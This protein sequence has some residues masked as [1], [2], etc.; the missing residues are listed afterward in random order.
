MDESG[1]YDFFENRDQLEGQ[2]IAW[3]TRHDAPRWPFVVFIKD[4][5]VDE[6][7][8]FGGFF[9]TDSAKPPMSWSVIAAGYMS[10]ALFQWLNCW[11][12][13]ACFSM[14]RTRWRVS[15]GWMTLLRLWMRFLPGF[16]LIGWSSTEAVASDGRRLHL[17]RG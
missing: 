13:L 10:S 8:I 7:I 1:E 14:R 4:E 5:R 6:A 2:C 3:L 9:G 16:L 17:L 11:F 15:A 12:R